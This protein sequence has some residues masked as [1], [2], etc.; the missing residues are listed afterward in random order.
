[1]TGPLISR[2]AYGAPDHQATA[3]LPSGSPARKGLPLPD[4]EGYK[5]FSK[6]EDD[7]REPDTSPGPSSRIRGPD[8]WAKEEDLAGETSWVGE[9]GVTS[10][11]HPGAGGKDPDDASKTK[12]PYRNDKPDTHNASVDPAFVAALHILEQKR[13]LAVRC[14]DLTAVRVAATAEQILSGL[15]PKFVARSRSVAVN[16][17]RADRKNLRWVFSVRGNNVYAVKIRAKRPRRNTTKFSKMDLELACSCPAWQWQGPEF[18]SSGGRSPAPSSSAAEYQLGA[19]MGTA[20][21]PDIRDPARQ[22]FVCKHVAAV[23]AATRGWDIP[24]E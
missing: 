13:P 14:R 15:N 6:P 3:Q 16:L 18:H 4:G 22:N 7:I 23:L 9:R 2:P 5:T 19:L 12:Y 21:P 17:K 10:P 20:S 11:S 24:N 1:M 8:D